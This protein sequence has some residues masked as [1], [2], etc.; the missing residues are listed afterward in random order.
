MAVSVEFE[1]DNGQVLTDAACPMQ[2]S[3]WTGYGDPGPARPAI[4]ST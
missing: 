1:D 4:G 3:T 2:S